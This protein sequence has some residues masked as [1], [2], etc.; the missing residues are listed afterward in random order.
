MYCDQHTM[1]EQFLDNV[2]HSNDVLHHTWFTKQNTRL[3]Y[4]TFDFYECIYM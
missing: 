3:E 2:E 4:A 1:Y